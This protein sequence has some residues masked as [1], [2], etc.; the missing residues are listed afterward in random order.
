[1][2]TEEFKQGQ[3]CFIERGFGHC[4]EQIGNEPTKFFALFNSPTFEEISISKWTAGNPASLLADNFQISKDLAGKLPNKR[5]GLSAS[6]QQ[7]RRIPQ[8]FSA[9]SAAKSK[10]LS[11]R[12]SPSS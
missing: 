2:K 10:R 3:I 12:T 5:W 11:R 9:A 1:M 8:K 6:W 7:W 4:V